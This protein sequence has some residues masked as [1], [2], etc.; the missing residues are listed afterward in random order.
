ML[1]EPIYLSIVHMY[2]YLYNYII[3]IVYVSARLPT[4]CLYHYVWKAPKATVWVI[5]GWGAHS[6]LTWVETKWLWFSGFCSWHMTQL[7]TSLVVGLEHF[8]FSIYIILYYIYIYVCALLPTECLYHYIW[9]APK[10][11]VWVIFGVGAHSNLTWVETK[12]LG[13]SGSCFPSQVDQQEPGQF[14]F[15]ERQKDMRADGKEQWGCVRPTWSYFRCEHLGSVVW[16]HHLLT[17][18]RERLYK[19]MVAAVVETVAKTSDGAREGPCPG[20]PSR[21]PFERIR[22]P[23]DGRCGWRALLAAEDPAAFKKVPRRAAAFHPPC[24]TDTS[25][26]GNISYLYV[27]IYIYTNI[28]LLYIYVNIHMHIYLYIYRY[29]DINI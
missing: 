4:E 5:F 10:A 9:K 12:W 8:L 24:I 6:N 2:I 13:F 25:F 18:N 19:Q 14:T 22:M 20:L 7:E 11:T 27:Y 21:V 16:I 1:C 15:K 17:S 28:Y 3:Y 29:I 26:S 23:A